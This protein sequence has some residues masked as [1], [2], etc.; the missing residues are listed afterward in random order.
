MGARALV[1]GCMSLAAANVDHAGDGLHQG[2][3]INPELE[4][5]SSKGFFGKDYPRDLRPKADEHFQMDYPYP[6]VQV[7]DDFDKDFV[8]DENSDGGRW[9]TQMEYDTVRSQLVKA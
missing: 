8:K 4:P 2:H 5:K 3:R 9:D 1:F 6:A 7:T